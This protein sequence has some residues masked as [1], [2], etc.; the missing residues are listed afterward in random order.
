VVEQVTSVLPERMLTRKT[1]KTLAEFIRP[2]V[3]GNALSCRVADRLASCV[4]GRVRK[5]GLAVPSAH[6]FLGEITEGHDS[7]RIVKRAAI[8]F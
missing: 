6:V 4:G 7:G 5:A 8:E 1:R 2:L 3:S